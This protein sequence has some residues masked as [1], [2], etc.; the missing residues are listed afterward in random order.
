MSGFFGPVSSEQIFSSLLPN[1]FWVSPRGAPYAT[2]GAALAA[3]NALPSAPSLTNP[4]VIFV[5]P[6]TYTEATHVIPQ[7]VSVVGIVK[8]T[9]PGVRLVNNSGDVF[10]ASGYNTFQNLTCVQ[11]STFGTWFV[12]GQNN[13][14]ISLL[15]CAMLNVTGGGERQ[16]FLSVNGSSWARITAQGCIVNSQT[17]GGGTLE[18]VV[19]LINTT[20]G[21]RFCDSWFRDVFI[22]AYQLTGFCTAIFCSGVQDVRI[23]SG[24]TLRGQAPFFTG[25][26]LAK[27][28]ITSGTPQLEC[29][30]LYT[31]GNSVGTFCE[32]GTVLNLI[33][34][35]CSTSSASAGTVVNHNSYN[36]AAYNALPI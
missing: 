16:G 3:I 35:D 32:A 33:N 4:A 28:A 29:R 36:G 20:T 7:Y 25:A 5:N 2:I 8:N 13:T 31:G 21:V 12:N 15:D 24:C 6:G 1:S 23:E 17:P 22:D 19:S 10:Q 18:A 34:S 26:Y 27:G 14:D 9:W 11:G 30:H